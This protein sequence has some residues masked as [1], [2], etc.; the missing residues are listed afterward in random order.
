MADA[1]P[2]HDWILDVLNDLQLYAAQNGLTELARGVEALLP[3]AQADI[4]AA[5][6]TDDGTP[7]H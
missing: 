2:A 3:M 4:A 6:R 1:K 7:V 5:G